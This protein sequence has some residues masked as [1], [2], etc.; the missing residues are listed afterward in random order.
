MAMTRSERLVRWLA[1]AACLLCLAGIGYVI[2]LISPSTHSSASLVQRPMTSTNQELVDGAQSELVSR[3]AASVPAIVAA[4]DSA[5]EQEKRNRPWDGGTPPLRYL[6]Y[7]LGDINNEE[8]REVL[9]AWVQQTDYA[10]IY[11]FYAAQ[12]LLRTGDTAWLPLLDDM[13]HLKSDEGER[14]QARFFVLLCLH[15]EELSAPALLPALPYIRMAAEDVLA[16]KRQA[17]PDEV[18]AFVVILKKI[19]NDE[20][21]RLIVRLAEGD[22]SFRQEIEKR[23]GKGRLSDTLNSR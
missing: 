7:A 17:R 22:E 6:L 23:I 1:A 20:A 3:G 8:A 18:L 14:F 2:Y 15:A 5:P 13:L 4:L 10:P 19:N 12:A 11:R 16:G 21:R 9:Y